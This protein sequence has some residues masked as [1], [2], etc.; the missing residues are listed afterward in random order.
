LPK[1]DKKDLELWAGMLG[2]RLA[3]WEREKARAEKEGR[4]FARAKL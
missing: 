2:P 4:G 1:W 3:A